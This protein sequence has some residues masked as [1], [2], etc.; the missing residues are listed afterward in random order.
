MELY[1]AYY[2]KKLILLYNFIP[3]TNKR[4]QMKNTKFSSFTKRK[5]NIYI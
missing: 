4:K 3:L 5:K 1:Q 2:S